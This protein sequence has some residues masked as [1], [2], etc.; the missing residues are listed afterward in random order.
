MQKWED[1]VL[2]L[3]NDRWYRDDVEI[4]RGNIME[5][6]KQ[7]IKYYMDNMGDDGWEFCQREGLFHYIKRLKPE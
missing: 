4:G 5:I 7:S 3:K 6:N 1:S 2:T